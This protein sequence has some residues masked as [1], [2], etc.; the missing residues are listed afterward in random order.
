MEYSIKS[1]STALTDT[2]SSC[3]YIPPSYYQTFVTEF[4]K[5]TD[6]D[7]KLDRYDFMEV[8]CA[9]VEILPIVSFL[10]GGYWMESRPEDYIVNYDG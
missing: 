6:A 9:S 8:N 5:A 4:I 1:G 3:S 2:G 7:V 10:Y